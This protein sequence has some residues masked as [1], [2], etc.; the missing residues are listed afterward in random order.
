MAPLARDEVLAA[1]AGLR[2]LIAEPGK[3]AR[4]TSRRDEIFES[5]TGLISIAGGK[6]T[7]FRRMAEDVMERVCARLGVPRADGMRLDPLPGGGFDGDLGALAHAVAALSRL[8]EYASALSAYRASDWDK[9]RTLFE[10]LTERNDELLYNVY[11]DRI[12]RFRQEP[13]E[14][15]WDGVFDHLSK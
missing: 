14:A 9:A 12:E 1:W 13:P 2:P 8:A 10:K 15:N 4:E 5:Q 3:S 6:L 7:G 11:L